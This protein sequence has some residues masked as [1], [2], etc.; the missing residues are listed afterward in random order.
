MKGKKSNKKFDKAFKLPSIANNA[1]IFLDFYF[2]CITFHDVRQLL[3]I[4]ND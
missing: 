2:F 1:G 4:Y 3:Y